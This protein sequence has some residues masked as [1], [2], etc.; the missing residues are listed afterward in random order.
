MEVSMLNSI[1]ANFLNKSKKFTSRINVIQKLTL[2][3]L[4]LMLACP[5]ATTAMTERL[6]ALWGRVTA[7]RESRIGT[8]VALT[9]VGLA[10]SYSFY[11]AFSEYYAT[12]AQAADRFVTTDNPNRLDE[13][14]KTALIYAV[15]NGNLDL[16][17]K[18]LNYGAQADLAGRDGFTPLMCLAQVAYRH[19]NVTELAELLISKIP[20]AKT[21][22]VNQVNSKAFNTTA[23]R[24]A[25]INYDL[26]ATQVYREAQQIFVTDFIKLLLK[27]GVD[28]SGNH[29]G[30]LIT[31]HPAVQ[32]A[33]AVDA[34]SIIVHVASGAT[35]SKG[36]I[37]PQPVK[38][39][40]ME[41]LYAKEA[42]QA[43]A[44]R[45]A[46]LAQRQATLAQYL[47]LA[48]QGDSDGRTSDNWIA[49]LHLLKCHSAII[50]IDDE[51]TVD[52]HT[53]LMLAARNLDWRM[54]QVLV[55]DGANV[56]AKDALGQT[57]L[58]YL[59]LSLKPHDPNN[60]KKRIFILETLVQAEQALIA[61]GNAG[62]SAAEDA[63]FMRYITESPVLPEEAY[64]DIKT[65]LIKRFKNLKHLA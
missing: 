4:V 40:I 13:H 25:L 35:E 10:I 41:E 36:H 14:G 23:L 32:T 59:A 61:D 21:V 53:A 17:E 31:E 63:R 8:A 38:L 20:V 11:R 3:G 30:K 45:Q 27:Y 56:R 15:T 42:E 24:L 7:T 65:N 22:Y 19:G 58:M 12:Q 64:R 33:Q 9:A 16:V 50:N 28:T 26:L 2:M 6:T 48:D 54:V 37:A 57:P 5:T 51:L 34:S 39:S 49:V 29:N 43:E 55:R 44:K 1:K 60:M 46:T 47:E 18:L 52:G 62:A